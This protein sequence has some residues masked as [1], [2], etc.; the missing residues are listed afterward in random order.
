MSM[1]FIEE[2]LQA[3]VEARLAAILATP[4]LL[5]DV[6]PAGR[7]RTEMTAWW[8]AAGSAPPYLYGFPRQGVQVPSY[9]MALRADVETDE[10]LGSNIGS[11]GRVSATPYDSFEGIVNDATI[12]IFTV[13]DGALA[14]RLFHAIL[15][16][17][18]RR[19]RTELLSAANGFLTVK[20]STGD[21]A[22]NEQMQPEFAFV[23][24]LRIVGKH[25]EDATFTSSQGP[26]VSMPVT[27]TFS[28]GS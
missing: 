6:F 10:L 11:S 9:S 12:E 16:D 22:P 25:V 27:G 4:A 5:D 17:A 14:A 26:I 3:V 18:I 20:L 28:V 2:Q 7:G 24:S 1:V 21:L 19:N 23:R 15:V 8:T 13:A